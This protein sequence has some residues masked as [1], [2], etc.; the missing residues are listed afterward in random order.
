MNRI[1][2]IVRSTHI[3]FAAIALAVAPCAMLT[4]KGRTWHRRWGKTYFWSMAFVALT[5]VVMSVI[6]SGLFL[7]M[8][9]IF[10]FYLAFSGYR[11]LYRKSP[12]QRARGGDWLAVVA[13]LVGGGGLFIY[14]ISQILGGRFGLHAIVFGT[15]GILLASADVRSFLRPPIDITEWWFTHM[16]RM[17]AAYIATVSAFSVVNFQ[18]LPPLV[19]WLWPTVI[20]GVGIVLWV[21]YYRKKFSQRAARGVVRSGG[22]TKPA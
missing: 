15:I 13:M 18:F 4:R 19:R 7:L 2:I 6:R 8:I 17:L 12:Q 20:G 22:A 16:I 5:A 10:S 14:G 21:G 1:F 3:L 11:I 9:A